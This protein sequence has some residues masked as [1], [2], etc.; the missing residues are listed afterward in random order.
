MADRLGEQIGNYR[1]VRL[2]GQGGFAEV[3]LGEHIHLK[4]QAAIKLLHTRLASNDIK[5]FLEEAKTIAHLDHPHIVGILDFGL[6]GNVPYLVMDFASHGTL[7]RLYPKGRRVPLLVIVNYS[8]QVASALQHAHNNKII[9]RDV[10]PENILLSKHDVALISDF[11][12]AVIAH[13]EA[14]LVT[15]EMAGTFYYMA[16]EQIR[17]KP[18]FASD[19]YALGIVVY[20][21]LCGVRPFQGTKT[22]IISQHLFAPP[23]SLDEKIPAV[24]PKIKQVVLK[25]LAKDPRGRFASIQEFAA[26]LEDANQQQERQPA[27]LKQQVPIVHASPSLPFS[28]LEDAQQ[29]ASASPSLG[30]LVVSHSGHG[31]VFTAVGWSPDEI[32][33]AS[34]S[35]DGAI[36]VWNVTTHEIIFDYFLDGYHVTTL[37]WSPTAKLCLAVAYSIGGVQI[38]DINEKKPYSIYMSYPNIYGDRK[39]IDVLKWS[40]DGR[41]IA[42]RTYY[43]SPF[44]NSIKVFRLDDIISSFSYKAHSDA[45]ISSFAWSPNSKRIASAARNVHIWDAAGGSRPSTFGDNGTQVND[46]VW[47]PNGSYLAFANEDKTVQV[48]DTQ[49][50]ILKRTY[51]GHYHGLTGKVKTLAWSP[52]GKYIASGGTDR[53][54]QVWYPM[55]GK[56]IATYTGHNRVAS[57]IA[58]SPDGQRIASISGDK[59]VHV[60]DALTGNPAF[61]YKGHSD[62]VWGIGW[63]LRGSFIASV[64]RDNTVQV[65]G[66]R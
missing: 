10:K 42:I 7:R 11:G 61:L 12:I 41:A 53:T 56:T 28:K 15:Q 17:G 54:I 9:H 46:V 34:A 59:I 51:H 13:S 21:W 8:N 1:L 26:A 57:M 27:P 20:E 35:R 45:P 36:Q 25:A 58:W 64:S 60:W 19:Q 50:G 6:E 37:E 32:Y 5:S 38:W 62:N 47:S 3:Y 18:Q 65:W 49:K 48:W 39:Q 22:E 29:I 4:T 16:P 31:Q 55:T 43:S 40:P 23:P 14:S 63:S 30:E 66:A 24:S 44:Q 2:L 52:D 33:I